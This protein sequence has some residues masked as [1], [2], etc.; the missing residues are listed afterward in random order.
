MEEQIRR[1][2]DLIL[3]MDSHYQKQVEFLKSRIARLQEQIRSSEASGQLDNTKAHETS[4]SGPPAPK[5]SDSRPNPV[6]I[7]NEPLP[8][9]YPV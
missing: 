8:K 1:Q 4:I 9:L 3:Q 7:V 2:R 6:R 5:R